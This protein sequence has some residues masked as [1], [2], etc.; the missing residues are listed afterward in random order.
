MPI[1]NKQGIGLGFTNLGSTVTARTLP[2]FSPLLKL[3]E[4]I[5][6]EKKKFDEE[7]A[8]ADPGIDVLKSKLLYQGVTADVNDQTKKDVEWLDEN[9]SKISD[10]YNGYN[11]LIVKSKEFQKMVG[12]WFVMTGIHRND[13]FNKQKNF[14]EAGTYISSN[15]VGGQLSKESLFDNTSEKDGFVKLSKV[16]DRQSYREEKKSIMDGAQYT[17][18]RVANTG[19]ITDGLHALFNAAKTET[20]AKDVIA[21]LAPWIEK[22][23]FPEGIEKLINGVWNHSETTNKEKVGEISAQIESYL[24][25]PQRDALTMEFFEENGFVQMDKDGNQYIPK[26]DITKYFAGKNETVEFKDDF[27]SW[28]SQD[29]PGIGGTKFTNKTDNIQILNDLS[30]FGNGGDEALD[31]KNRADLQMLGIQALQPARKYIQGFGGVDVR[32]G[33]A[34]LVSPEVSKVTL[35]NNVPSEVLINIGNSAQTPVFIPQEKEHMFY[36]LGQNGS[37]T[38]T[39]AVN[40]NGTVNKESIDQA[41]GGSTIVTNAQGADWLI[42]Q[43]KF[44]STSFNKKTKETIKQGLASILPDGTKMTISNIAKELKKKNIDNNILNIYDIKPTNTDPLP[45]NYK[46]MSRWIDTK[47]SRSGQTPPSNMSIDELMDNKLSSEISAQQLADAGIVKI[48]VAD[49][50]TSPYANVFSGSTNM[51]EKPGNVSDENFQKWSAFKENIETTNS[52]IGF[53][54]KNYIYLFQGDV[55]MNG[56]LFQAATTDNGQTKDYNTASGTKK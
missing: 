50:P 32:V 8:K 21:N 28:I 1:I 4:M 39:K 54:G 31:K 5:G 7:N 46:D 35:L 55:D 27:S 36:I 37:Y 16:G 49:L 52:I 53:L 18:D 23:V 44:P 22:G 26:K 25:K 33:D 30:G 45:M 56:Y 20:T 15:D 41:Y 48:D 40:A 14:T 13:L 42:H 3:Q 9:Y 11:S 12:D 24:D 10:K 43:M 2:D 6:G 19:K 38:Y 17:Y 51:T 34:N 29:L 47:A